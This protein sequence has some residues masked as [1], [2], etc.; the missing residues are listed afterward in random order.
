MKYWLVQKKGANFFMEQ[1]SPEYFINAKKMGLQYIRFGPNSLPATEK[2]FLIGDLDNFET[3]NMDDLEILLKILDDAYR[4]DI[5]IVLTMFEL[6]GQRYGNPDE[7][8]MDARLWEEEK[9]WI[10]SFNFWKELAAAV[11]DHPAIVAYN[12]INEPVSAY[13]YGFCEPDRKFKRWLNKVEGT[14]ADINLF[15]TLMIEAIREVDSDTPILLDGYFWTDPK[16]MPYLKAQDDP[17]T[18][19]AFHNPAPGKFSFLEHNKGRYS[20]PNTM[21]KYWG[22]TGP[23]TIEDLDRLLL[24]VKKFIT[25]NDVENFRIIASEFFCHRRI[26]GCAEYFSDLTTLY[27]RNQWH[28]SFWAFNI[29]GDYTGFDYQ[30]GDIP[31]SALFIINADKDDIDLEKFKNRV[32]NPAWDV[33]AAQFNSEP[34]DNGLITDEKKDNR[35]LNDLMLDLENEEWIIR[36]GAAIEIASRK[37]PVRDAVPKLVQ[38]LDDEEWLVR[39]SAIYALSQIIT[40]TDENVINKIKELQNDPEE[41][42][43]IE[44]GLALGNI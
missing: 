15:N 26:K 5:A 42:V 4:N 16:G 43:R 1:Y 22:S 32:K 31:D 41:Q 10:H 14:A 44:V 24:P 23:W 2:D 40:D 37:E 8:E 38:L 6:P 35:N 36:E 7:I 3:M 13:A 28:W 34:Y 21:P 11:K 29:Y 19:Y 33:L 12:P 25:D 9:Y 30:L 17:N 27:N 39:R 18:L 20:Y